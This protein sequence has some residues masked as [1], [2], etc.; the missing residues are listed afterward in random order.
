M[1]LRKS[2]NFIWRISPEATA[3]APP[4]WSRE[5]AEVMLAESRD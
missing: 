5:M 2:A 1:S 4:K 3:L